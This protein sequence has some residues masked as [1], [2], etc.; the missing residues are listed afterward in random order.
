[1]HGVECGSGLAEYLRVLSPETVFDRI[2]KSEV[3]ESTVGQLIII[4]RVAEAAETA[5]WVEIRENGR[6]LDVWPLLCDTN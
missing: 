2:Q 4:V 5:D 3:L 1:L 6:V